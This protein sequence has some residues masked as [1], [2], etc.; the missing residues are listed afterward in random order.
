MAALL[1][2]RFADAVWRQPGGGDAAGDVAS[3]Y[4]SQMARVFLGL[5]SQG[6][7]REPEHSVG[8]AA[9]RSTP[10][11]RSTPWLRKR[12]SRRTDELPAARRLHAV[13]TLDVAVRDLRRGAVS[14]HRVVRRQLAAGQQA[15]LPAAATLGR[16]YAG[17]DDDTMTR[18]QGFAESLRGS[19][20]RRPRGRLAELTK[21]LGAKPGSALRKILRCRRW[22]AVHEAISTRHRRAAARRALVRVDFNVPFDRNGGIADDSRIRAATPHDPL[23]PGATAPPSS[24]A[25]TSAGPTA[26]SSRRCA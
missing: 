8:H 24:S 26:R 9:R 14:Q 1:C 23:P 19:G 2:L 10:A 7:A 11:M 5:E 12:C 21:A 20:R 16:I 6:G 22:E 15:L 18:P 25:R 17:A 13:D 4:L 3:A